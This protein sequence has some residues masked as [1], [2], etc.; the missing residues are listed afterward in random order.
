MLLSRRNICHFFAVTIVTLLTACTTVG[1][2]FEKPDIPAPEQWVTPEGSGIE[3]TPY[4]LVEWW[5]VFDDPALDDLVGIARENNNNLQIAGL[6]VL[7]ARAQLGVAVGAQ[8]PQSQLAFGDATYIAPPENSGSTSNF[9][10]YGFGATASWEIDFW[11]RFKRGIESADAAFLAS[12]A[13]YDQTLVLL[14]AQVVDTYTLI[15]ATE[16]QLR[17]AHDN[18][19]IQQRSYDIAEVLY[20]NGADSELDMQQANTLLLS[21]QATIPD[22]E[23]SL[24]QAR[25][26]LS[27][28]LGESPGNVEARLD[29]SRGIPQVPSH[30]SV[31]FPADMLRRRPDVRQ[32]EYQAMSLNALVGLA[33][34]DLYPSFSLAGSIGL[35]AGSPGNSSFGDLFDS[36]ALTFSIGP[37]FVWPFLNYGRIKNNVRVQDARLQQALISYHETVIQAAR[38]A[39]DAMVGFNGATEQTRILAE[40]VVSA[41][42]S[43]DLSTLRYREGFSDYQ[44]VLDAQQALFT[45]QQRLATNQANTIRSLISLFKALGGGWENRDGLPYIDPETLEVMQ[46]RT[47]WGEMIETGYDPA[48]DQKS[49]RNPDW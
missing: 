30:I 14:T 9:W 42:R 11:G 34:A 7:E 36:D 24:R 13:A 33:V 47:D 3:S 37:S 46:Q 19:V 40:T 27:V 15:R 25:N 1:P 12:I 21:T 39:E 44:R 18:V 8:Y 41:K 5:R 29:N 28:L 10:Q 45:Q 32:A 6:R 35:S 20:R 43:N 22:L 48:A 17:I 16:E 26:A 38:E 4:Q 49:I 23:V 31:G 2:E